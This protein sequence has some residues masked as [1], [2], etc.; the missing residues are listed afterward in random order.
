M[1]T[2]EYVLSK[3]SKNWTPTSSSGISPLST[4]ICMASMVTVFRFSRNMYLSLVILIARFLY[5]HL[6]YFEL[7]S[8]LCMQPAQLTSAHKTSNLLNRFSNAIRSTF[9]KNSLT[10][11]EKISDQTTL[12]THHS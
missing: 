9:T 1:W 4:I 8:K 3:L 10:Q 5:G 11:Q 2:T 7:H 12:T 6:Q